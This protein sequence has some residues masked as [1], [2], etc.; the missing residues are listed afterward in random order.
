MIN[1]RVNVNLFPCSSILCAF[2]RVFVHEQAT[3]T[4]KVS[5]CDRS[6][7]LI[8]LITLSINIVSLTPLALCALCIFQTAPK[9]KATAAKKA[10]A[11]KATTAKKATAAKKATTKKTTV[12]KAVAKKATTKKK[13]TAKK[14]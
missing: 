6:E 8:V 4:K 2:A 12:K 11:K 10:P 13:T 9:K 14:Q 5:G 7:Q 1:L 3:V